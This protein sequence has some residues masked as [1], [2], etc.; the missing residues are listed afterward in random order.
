VAD[1]LEPVMK[2][3]TTPP[4]DVRIEFQSGQ[5]TAKKAATILA[6]KNIGFVIPSARQKQNLVVAFAKK[7]KVVYGKAFDTVR[8]SG[9]VNLDDLADVESNLQRITI[10]EIKSTRKKL[11]DD[12]SNYFFALTA[13]E[14]LVAQSLKNQFR[15]VFV[16]T[17]TGAHLEMNLNKIFERAKGIYPTWSISF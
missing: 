2:P 5:K 15:F 1:Y 6:A 4:T 12:F 16:N 3:L 10:F 9:S 11:P 7:G 8:I 13:A 14:L 17:G